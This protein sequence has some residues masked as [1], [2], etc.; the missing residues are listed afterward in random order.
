MLSVGHQNVYGN[1]GR[2]FGFEEGPLAPHTLTQAELDAAR[3][4]LNAALLETE[5]LTL[6]GEAC[7][8]RD[9]K[10][11]AQAEQK[12]ARQRVRELYTLLGG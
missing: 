7:H 9:L 1:D 8:D 5:K 6:Y 12:R 11:W 4:L 2:A 3:K 10:S